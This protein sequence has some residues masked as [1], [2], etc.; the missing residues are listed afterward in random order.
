MFRKQAGAALVAEF[1]GTSLLTLAVLSVQRSTIGVPYFVAIAAGL[2]AAMLG[3]MFGSISGGYANPAITIGLWTA[4]KLSTV[5]A[6][7][8]VAVQ[9][10]GGWAAYGLYSYFANTNLQAVGGTFTG[11]VMVAEAVGAFVLALGFAV[12][13]YRNSLTAGARSALVGVS[14]TI[15]IIIAATV[16]IGIINQAVALGMNAWNVFG[17]MGWLTYVLGPILG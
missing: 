11:R 10:L 12:V 14:L 13:A 3:L 17:S 1:V 2:V 16:G 8:Y 6:V 4:R 9:L 15:G 7:L 5:T